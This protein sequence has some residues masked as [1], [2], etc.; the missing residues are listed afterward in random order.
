ML[1]RVA[2]TGPW[3]GLPVAWNRNLSFDEDAYRAD[4]ERTCKAGVPGIY[5]GGTTGEFYATEF[6]DFMPITKATVEECRKHSTPVM[7]GVTHTSTLG[8]VRRAEFARQLG[9]D[10]IQVALPYWMPVDDREI[11]RFFTE[12]SAAAKGLAFSIYETTR[13]RKTLSL[14]QHREIKEAIPGY[15]VVKANVGTLG[16]RKQGCTN[17]SELV[18]VFV[19]ES[20]W[21]ELGPCGAAG[22]A[23]ALVYMNPRVILRVWDL[24]KQKDWLALGKWRAAYKRYREEVIVPLVDKGYT[25][26]AL[27]RLQGTA[28]GFLRTSLWSRGGPYPSATAEDLETLKTWL[29]NNW[30]EFLEM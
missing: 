10:A 8:A 2:M 11:A 7:I 18:N 23:S 28:C 27:D 12:V 14:G 30:P 4:V 26:T 3:A 1:S 13:T 21:P 20:L 16:C 19:H 6:E 29:A 25:D 15:T 9:A 17:L 5:T 24:L 22:S